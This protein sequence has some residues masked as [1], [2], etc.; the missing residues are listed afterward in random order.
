[1]VNLVRYDSRVLTGK[2]PEAEKGYN[3]FINSVR[4]HFSSE[5]DFNNYKALLRK[6]FEAVLNVLNEYWRVSYSR[7]YFK[8]LITDNKAFLS[9][10]D[11]GRPPER[12]NGLE[13]LL[14]FKLEI[15][16][17]DSRINDSVSYALLIADD[18]AS[19]GLYFNDLK[20]GSLEEKVY[21]DTFSPYQHHER[22][23]S[24]FQ[25]EQ[26][27]YQGQSYDRSA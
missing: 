24:S 23:H 7:D 8:M 26:A 11:V 16:S 20:R 15:P 12:I 21:K 4:K 5:K 27:H 17:Y 22:S 13:E 10:T 14:S 18:L 9:T 25:T 6:N 3:R 1:M 19:K 2:H